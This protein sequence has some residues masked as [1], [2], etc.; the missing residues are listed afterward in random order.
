[1]AKRRTIKRN[2]HAVCAGL[3]TEA[4]AASLYSAESD[5][6]NVETLL[7]SILKLEKEF[8]SRASHVEPGLAPKDYFAKVI[9]DFNKRYVEIADVIEN[10][11]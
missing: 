11:H 5:L 4:V 9:D 1:M 7:H 10:I 8:V 3:W 6:D 2:I